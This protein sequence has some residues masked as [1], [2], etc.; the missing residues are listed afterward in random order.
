[1]RNTSTGR[2]RAGRSPSAI[3]S[4]A[5]A[6]PLALAGCSSGGPDT[7]E[8]FVAEA[9]PD[10]S[11]GVVLAAQGEELVLCEGWGPADDPAGAELGCDTAVDIMSM[12]KQFTAAAILK[13]EMLDRLDVTDPIGDHLDHVPGDKQ[14]ITLQHLLTHTSGL[15]PELGHDDDPVTRDELV[16]DAMDSALRAEPGTAYDYSNLGYSL[17]AAVVETASG[18]GYEEFLAEHLLGPAG[19]TAT[20]Y[21]LPDWDSLDVAVEYD[22]D[23]T[24]QGRPVE[25]PW[26]EDG[27]WWNLRGNGGLLSTATDMYR[28]HVAL[29]GDEILDADAKSQLFEPRVREEPDD[30]H[31]AY[32]W[33]ITE[34]DGQPL[35]WHNGGNA[36]AYGE[37]ARTTDGSAMLF[38]VAPQAVGGDP[39]GWDFEE[40][41]PD[42]TEGILSRLP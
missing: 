18:T 22:E 41:G 21:V 9:P 20:G 6:L 7:L 40:I 30:T 32:G 33:V 35:A 16:A 8:A 19:M 24:A 28:W 37:L 23:G 36:H 15:V 13:L 42:F 38:W 2:R 11:R 31:Y 26:A 12:T 34:Y 29:L 5:A 27:P 39:D 10:G 14:A 1:M 25:R 4:L 17:L 3:I